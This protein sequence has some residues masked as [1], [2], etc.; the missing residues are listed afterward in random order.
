MAAFKKGRKI[1]RKLKK[2][3][4][5]RKKVCP[6]KA[7]STLVEQLNYKNLELLMRF[8][9]DRGKILPRRITGVSAKYQRALALEVKRARQIALLPY[10]VQ[11]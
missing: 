10:A 9:T 2:R 8:I 5:R 6:F 4:F 3:R 1:T 7:D 11:D